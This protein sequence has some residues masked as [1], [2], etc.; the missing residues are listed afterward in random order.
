[1]PVF[2][3]FLPRRRAT[4][5]LFGA[6]V[7][8]V[9][10]MYAYGPRVSGF[11]LSPFYAALHPFGTGVFIYAALR[12]ACLALAKGGIEWRGTFYPLRQLRE[13]AS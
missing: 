9:V 7:L 8:A 3:V 1:L 4:R 11:A 6:D 2:G 5:L 13:D 12:C 10:A